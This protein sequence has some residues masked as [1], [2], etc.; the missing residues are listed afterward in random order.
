MIRWMWIDILVLNGNALRGDLS[1]TNLFCTNIKI[2]PFVENSGGRLPKKIT[3]SSFLARFKRIISDNTLAY[4]LEP[5]D[6]ISCFEPAYKL[7]FIL[8]LIWK[9]NLWSAGMHLSRA[10]NKTLPP[11]VCMLGAW[12][13]TLPDNLTPIFTFQYDNCSSSCFCIFKCRQHHHLKFI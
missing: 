13:I 11:P 2:F 5:K 9:M 3:T 12:T 7:P 6:F 10:S 4:K 1:T 8:S